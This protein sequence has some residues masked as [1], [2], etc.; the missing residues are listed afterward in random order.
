M[1]C[2]RFSPETGSA[3]GNSILI[4]NIIQA[5]IMQH[6]PRFN[7]GKNLSV[8]NWGKHLPVYNWLLLTF[9][10]LNEQENSLLEFINCMVR[11]PGEFCQSP[12]PTF[13]KK[14]NGS[15]SDP[16][17]EKTYPARFS[18]PYFKLLWE[19]INNIF[20]SWVHPQQKVFRYGLRNDFLS[21]G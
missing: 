19:G 13:E 3:P 18:D 10:Y 17:E 5:L 12:D 2:F 21:R 7:W 6:L 14:K 1:G 4:E 16:R 8:F 11:D 9:T 15:G 20:F